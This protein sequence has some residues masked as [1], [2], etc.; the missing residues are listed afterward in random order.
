MAGN[1][2]KSGRRERRAD[3]SKRTRWRHVLFTDGADAFA[4]SFPHYIRA[5]FPNG[6][7]PVY[8]CPVCLRAFPIEAIGA[9]TLTTEHA[10]PKCL[11]G[12]E[13]LLTCKACNN[14]AGRWLDVAMLKGDRPVAILRGEHEREHLI[15]FGINDSPKVTAVITATPTGTKGMISD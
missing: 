13:L 12:P 4:R 5:T 6:A 2:E 9:R 11:G 10:P 8:V 1:P 3:R 15:R 14:L 7:P